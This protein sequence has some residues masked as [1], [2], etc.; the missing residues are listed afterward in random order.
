MNVYNPYVTNIQTN[1][2]GII[3]LALNPKPLWWFLTHNKWGGCNA[4]PLGVVASSIILQHK[5]MSRIVRAL[6]MANAWRPLESQTNFVYECLL[7][8]F[9][10][11][12]SVINL[13]HAIH[14][15]AIS[16]KN[17]L[18]CRWQNKMTSP[19][20]IDGM[21]LTFSMTMLSKTMLVRLDT[22]LLWHLMIWSA[23]SIW[24]FLVVKVG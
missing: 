3:N 17:S 1:G 5:P 13:V 2:K 19:L 10:P 12:M 8:W 16:I 21:Y 18:I 9:A 11:N 15:L 20:N 23:L 7:F 14:Y 6:E 4:D 22:D 24:T